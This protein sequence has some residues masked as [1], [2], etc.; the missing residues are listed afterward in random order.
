MLWVFCTVFQV[1]Y[2]YNPTRYQNDKLPSTP[3]HSSTS[4]TTQ[5]QRQHMFHLQ[6]QPSWCYPCWYQYEHSPIWLAPSSI[7]SN[8]QRVKHLGCTTIGEFEEDDTYQDEVMGH[9]LC[10]QRGKWLKCQIISVRSALED[11][12]WDIQNLHEAMNNLE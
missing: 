4:G 6:H 1:P 3:K 7:W 5:Q 11:I 2:L 12:R 9:I 10:C 8:Y